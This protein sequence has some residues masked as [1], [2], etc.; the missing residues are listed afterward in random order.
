MDPDYY[1]MNLTEAMCEDSQ[2]LVYAKHLKTEKILKR[3]IIISES[4]ENLNG[5][6]LFT[7]KTD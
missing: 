4:S 2:K 7:D 5:T 6:Y 1:A 3:S